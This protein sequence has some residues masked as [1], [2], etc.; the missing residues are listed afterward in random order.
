MKTVHIYWRRWLRC[1][2]IHDRPG[3]HWTMVID[4]NSCTG[5]GA[6]VVACNAENNVPV[7]GKDQ[8]R[9]SRE[10]HWMRIDRYYTGESR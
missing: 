10:M 2:Y 5:C 9:R 3:H 7:V 4:L 1:I 6:C 8:V